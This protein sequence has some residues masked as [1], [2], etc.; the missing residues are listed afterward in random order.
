MIGHH[1]AADAV[2]RR[3]VR[4]LARERDLD[5]GG[6]PGDKIGQLP[7]SDPLEALVDLQGDGERAVKEYADI[8][9]RAVL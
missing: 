9:D 4:G 6:A 7:L 1:E 2:S 3:Q 8:R 5:A